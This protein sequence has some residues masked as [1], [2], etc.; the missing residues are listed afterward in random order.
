MSNNSCSL[1]IGFRVD[2]DKH[3]FSS[4]PNRWIAP[5]ISRSESCR[6]YRH[7]TALSFH[8]F[9]KLYFLL[10][11]FI[12]QNVCFNFIFGLLG[13]PILCIVRF[14]HLHITHTIGKWRAP[15]IGP[16]YNGYWVPKIVTQQKE[17][18]KKII[19]NI[20]HTLVLTYL[21]RHHMVLHDRWKWPW[22]N[23]KKRS[24]LFSVSLYYSSWLY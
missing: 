19:I 22:R 15:N 7:D 10:R 18:A 6:L 13:I 4:I 12:L 5:T 3:L 23:N 20:C 17:N 2:F 14:S 9:S 11:V 8:N 1:R 21:I 24:Q 16:P